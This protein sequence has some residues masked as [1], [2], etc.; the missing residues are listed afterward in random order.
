MSINAHKTRV[1]TIAQKTSIWNIYLQSKNKEGQVCKSC[2][3]NDIKKY[4]NAE[5]WGVKQ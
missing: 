3:I 2:E 1:N 4:L 5:Q